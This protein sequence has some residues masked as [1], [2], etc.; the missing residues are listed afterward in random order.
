MLVDET[1]G[2]TKFLKSVAAFNSPNGFVESVF[3]ED[4]LD[5]FIGA[6]TPVQWAPSSCRLKVNSD[7]DAILKS[8]RL[9]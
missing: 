7:A 8:S 3:I 9:S 1:P 5:L 4:P 2:S 6:P